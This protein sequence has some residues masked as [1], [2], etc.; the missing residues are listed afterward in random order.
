LFGWFFDGTSTL[1]GY[2]SVIRLHIC[3]YALY[4]WLHICGDSTSYCL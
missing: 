2:Y 3:T 1:R 4:A